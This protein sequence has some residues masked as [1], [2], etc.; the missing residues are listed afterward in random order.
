MSEKVELSVHWQANLNLKEDLESIAVPKEVAKDP[1]QLKG[2]LWD[3]MHE[4]VMDWGIDLDIV[5]AKDVWTN[6]D[7]LDGGWEEP[8]SEEV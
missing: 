3:A 8:E 6:D 4:R 2:W 5:S 7:A 1:E